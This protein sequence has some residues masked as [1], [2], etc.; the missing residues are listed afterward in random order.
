[1]LN[2]NKYTNEELMETLKGL[3]EQRKELLSMGIPDEAIGKS[4]IGLGMVFIRTVLKER[5]I[6]I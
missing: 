5:G 2:L 3:L 6:E 1:M 4:Q